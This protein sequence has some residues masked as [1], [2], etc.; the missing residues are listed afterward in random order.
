MSP[1]S[2][3]PLVVAST[4]V[5]LLVGW[6]WG[7]TT[8]RSAP[9]RAQAAGPTDATA[10]HLAA[11]LTAVRADLAELERRRAGSDRELLARVRDVESSARSLG[12]ALRVPHVRG[13]WGELHL[14]RAVELAGMVAH[15]DF[16]EQ[17]SHV[18]EEGARTRPD[19]VVRIAGGRS[20]VVDAK[21]PMD[22]W[23]SAVE[24][25]DP[26]RRLEHERRHATVVR[27]HV[28]T[29]ARRQYGRAV[30]GAAPIVVVYLPGE[31]LLRAALEHDPR[32]VDD[33][34]AQDV[35][36]AT[37]ASL[38]TILRGVSL[39]WQEHA[40][41]DNAAQIAALGARL[42]DRIGVVN[43][44]LARLGRALDASVR[45]YDDTVGSVR[46]RLLPTARGLR[47]LDVPASRTFDEVLTLESRGRLE[48]P[49]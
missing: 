18:T 26:D 7:R 49:A 4:L 9:V 46:T 17:A 42:H 28:R 13:R 43:D 34:A 37:P 25:S 27:D 30:P 10:E 32:I 16:A 29:V 44:H 11:I 6:W 31:D 38:V 36:L 35:V 23:L 47:E 19:L 41:A 39:G 1:L 48:E 33:A 8:A 40:L 45:A 5:A 15:C 3:E 21:A 22:A 14:R 24:S 12:H 2:V 20:L